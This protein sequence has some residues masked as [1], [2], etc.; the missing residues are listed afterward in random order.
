MGITINGRSLAQEAMLRNARQAE[1]LRQSRINQGAEAIDQHFAG[2]DDNFFKNYQDSY[3]QYYTPQLDDQYADARKRLSL[4]LARTGN[5]NAS[6]GLEQLGKLRRTYDTG[7]TD[8]ANKAL[9]AVNEL[10]SNIDR[11]KT[12]LYQDNLAIADPGSISVSAANIANSLQPAQFANP[13]A[14]AFSGA[15]DTLGSS[16]QAYN[17]GRAQAPFRNL[18]VQQQGGKIG[19][20][21]S[22][23]N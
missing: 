7:R 23:Y 2:F 21:V 1:R 3:N 6:T 13:L 19:K 16:A 5:L 9:N 18:G 12:Q 20:N 15:F 4:Q 11:S 10:R 22:Y 17:T 14:N 8:I